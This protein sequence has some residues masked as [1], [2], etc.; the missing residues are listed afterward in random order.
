MKSA[1]QAPIG[2]HFLAVR[3]IRR[4]AGP[5]GLENSVVDCKGER[6][7]HTKQARRHGRGEPPPFAT[8]RNGCCRPVHRFGRGRGRPG[9]PA[10]PPVCA[11]LDAPWHL[12]PPPP[13]PA[14]SSPTPRFLPPP[15]P[16]PRTGGIAW[17]VHVPSGFFGAAAWGG[18]ARTVDAAPLCWAPR[19]AAVRGGA[20]HNG[21]EGV[22]GGAG[23][24]AGGGV[25]FGVPPRGRYGCGRRPFPFDG[26]G[27]GRGALVPVSC[28]LCRSLASPLR[29]AWL[30]PARPTLALTPSVAA[31]PVQVG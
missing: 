25:A 14:P 3:L 4:W 22:S 10:R 21:R 31:R 29:L 13:T 6:R 20:A 23:A 2:S 18:P 24:G 8:Q 1:P 27:A 17:G 16:A 15:P 5:V 28:S 7:R 11:C 26:A 19:V 30:G 12:A 9:R